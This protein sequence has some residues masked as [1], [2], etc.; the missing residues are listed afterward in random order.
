MGTRVYEQERPKRR[1]ERVWA[2]MTTSR[3]GFNDT[4]GRRDTHCA[5]RTHIGFRG[6]ISGRDRIGNRHV[7]SYF[8]PS[9]VRH[10]E[11]LRL[12]L[13]KKDKLSE[14]TVYSMVYSILAGFPESC[15]FWFSDARRWLGCACG[16]ILDD[17]TVE[18][19][20]GR[21]CGGLFQDP[22]GMNS[23]MLQY[24]Y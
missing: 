11:F 21:H 23:A 10:D 16:L 14:G 8:P 19:V 2:K 1:V 4:R 12:R 5:S 22:V 6:E 18:L 3:Q 20:F 7:C 15:A 13:W 17:Y 9:S 24:T